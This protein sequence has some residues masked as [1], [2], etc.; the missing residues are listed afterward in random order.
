MLDELQS[1]ACWAAFNECS[2]PSIA[3]IIFENFGALED[4]LILSK[5]TKDHIKMN[6]N[7]LELSA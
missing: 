3:T 4:N 2:E 1:K 7:F 6:L 5:Y